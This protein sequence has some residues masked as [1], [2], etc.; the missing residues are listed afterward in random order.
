[1]GACAAG[2]IGAYGCYCLAARFSVRPIGKKV[3]LLSNS[4]V[5]IPQ[6]ITIIVSGESN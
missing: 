3:L 2:D 1:M 5:D 4:V 6:Q